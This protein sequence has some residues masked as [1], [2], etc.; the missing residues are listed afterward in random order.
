LYYNP[1]LV[2]DGPDALLARAVAFRK[3]LDRRRLDVVWLMTGEKL[4]IGDNLRGEREEWVGRLELS[5]VGCFIGGEWREWH[6]GYINRGHGS[7]EPLTW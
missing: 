6:V 4:L 2:V 5:A 3:R 1:S 7:R